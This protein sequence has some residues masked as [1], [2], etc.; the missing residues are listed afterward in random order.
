MHIAIIIDG[1]GRW[2]IKHCG[3]RTMG[4]EEGARNVWKLI[5]GLPE[6]VGYLT[7][8]GLSLDNIRKRPKEEIE[9]LYLIFRDTFSVGLES[10]QSRNIRLN[11]LGDGNIPTSLL[12]L[13]RQACHTTRCNTGVVLSIALSYGSRAEITGAAIKLQTRSE[14]ITRESLERNLD[15]FGLPDVDLLIRTGGEKR[16][17]DFLLWQ[18]AYAELFFTDTLWPDFNSDELMQIVD[19]YHRRERRFGGLNE[20]M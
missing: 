15:T 18:V 17:S 2:G 14:A 16:L 20:S 1:N 12:R 19:E 11:Y 13:I 6:E 9:R 3:V 4:H 7:L 5:Q 8:Y 10:V